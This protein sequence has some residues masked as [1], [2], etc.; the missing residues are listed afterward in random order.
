[1]EYKW[2]KSLLPNICKSPSS[3]ALLWNL[4]PVIGMLLGLK[5][6]GSIYHY[7]GHGIVLDRTPFVTVTSQR[8]AE[9][10]MDFMLQDGAYMVG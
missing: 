8:W 10:N 6:V 3:S 7:I 5:F 1:M 9:E 2:Y 4:T